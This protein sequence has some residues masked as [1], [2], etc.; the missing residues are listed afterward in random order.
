[1][2]DAPIFYFPYV[3]LNETLLCR[4]FGNQHP[5]PVVTG[6]S[7]FAKFIDVQYLDFSKFHT[8]I[9]D[10]IYIIHEKALLRLLIVDS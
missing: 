3:N 10:Y 9:N 2:V 4:A 5:C 1:M 6:H 8:R 7:L